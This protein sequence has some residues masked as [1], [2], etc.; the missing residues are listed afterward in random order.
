MSDDALAEW[1]ML[2]RRLEQATAAAR[3]LEADRSNLAAV[4]EPLKTALRLV[5]QVGCALLKALAQDEHKVARHY[6]NRTVFEF[7]R[8]WDEVMEA[9]VLLLK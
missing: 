8:E 7:W 9:A 2:H 6:L 3:Q 1:D 4:V 5:I